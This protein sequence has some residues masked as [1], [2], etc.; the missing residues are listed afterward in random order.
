MEDVILRRMKLFLA[1]LLTLAC[2]ATASAAPIPFEGF[3][4]Y[5][6][7][8]TSGVYV[9][10][11]GDPA[12]QWYLVV[13]PGPG[14]PPLVKVY[15]FIPGGWSTVR[16]FYAYNP[17]FMGGVTVSCA[18]NDAADILWVITGAG[19]GGGPHV[20]VFGFPVK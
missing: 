14:A 13:G 3:F 15:R 17:A 6:S 16:Q 4:A 9:A 2:V 19:P 1:S 20:S 7:T 8:Q 11:C 18:F 10:Q 5:P 12:N